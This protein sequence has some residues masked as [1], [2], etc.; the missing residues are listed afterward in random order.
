MP[1]I[2]SRLDSQAGGIMRNTART[3]RL[4]SAGG[5]KGTGRTSSNSVKKASSATK[6][7]TQNS[8]KLKSN[9]LQKSKTRAKS[10]GRNDEYR[11]VVHP[12]YKEDVLIKTGNRTNKKAGISRD[13]PYGTSSFPKEKAGRNSSSSKIKTV[14]KIEKNPAKYQTT[15]SKYLTQIR[16]LQLKKKTR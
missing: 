13:Y 4:E 2:Y 14:S 1:S 5:S 3:A 8:T 11:T 15:G 9:A 6:K 12:V 16:K 7:A 10:K